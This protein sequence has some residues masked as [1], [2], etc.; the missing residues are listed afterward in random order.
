[1]ALL[2]ATEP[3]LHRIEMVV[4]GRA[5]P[6]PSAWPLDNMFVKIV[7]RTLGLKGDAEIYNGARDIYSRQLVRGNADVCTDLDIDARVR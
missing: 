4:D 5:A 2:A 6:G 1:M 3:V 7:A